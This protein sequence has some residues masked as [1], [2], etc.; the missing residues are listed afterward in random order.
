MEMNER[1]TLAYIVKES[2]ELRVSQ[3]RVRNS[4]E[5]LGFPLL[6]RRNLFPPGIVVPDLDSLNLLSGVS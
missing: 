2:F 6:L 4:V 3:Q 1:I 5:E